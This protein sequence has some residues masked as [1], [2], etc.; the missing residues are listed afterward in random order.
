MP[1]DIHV[2]INWRRMYWYWST[3]IEAFSLEKL[4]NL[5]NIFNCHFE[6]P[7]NIRQT[8]SF[9]FSYNFK[10]H[11]CLSSIKLWKSVWN[12]CYRLFPK[13]N[14]FFYYNIIVLKNIHRFRWIRKRHDKPNEKS[15]EQWNFFS[16]LFGSFQGFQS[17]TF[18]HISSILTRR[19]IKLDE[20][21]PWLLK[22]REDVAVLKAKML[23][24]GR[25][26]E[27]SIKSVV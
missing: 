23:I 24:N 20:S 11:Y 5:K 22:L 8:N 15:N 27:N 18:Y 26:K 2:Y 19:H 25:P 13:L 21:K 3:S 6:I 4:Q 17:R 1:V 7:V 14:T 12:Q 9:Q 10:C 16:H